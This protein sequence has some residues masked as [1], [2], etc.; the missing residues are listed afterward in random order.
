MSHMKKE[1]SALNKI[2][3]ILTMDNT[4][5]KKEVS[6]LK[7]LDLGRYVVEHDDRLTEIDEELGDIKA[8]LGKLSG[9]AL[10]TAMGN[11]QIDGESGDEWEDAKECLNTD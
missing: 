7:K 8:I 4:I 9:G 5:L 1:I 6:G 2:N 3:I 11:M 10:E